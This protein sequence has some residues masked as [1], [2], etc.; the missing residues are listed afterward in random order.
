MY[1]YDDILIV[2]DSWCSERYNME[3]WPNL[4]LYKLTGSS[5]ISPRGKGFGGCA[6]WST[7]NKLYEELK[8]KPAKVIII[9]HTDPSRLPSDNN[10]PMT[11]DMAFRKYYQKGRWDTP[12]REAKVNAAAEY[13]SHLYCG[14]FYRWA[15]EKWFEE[16]DHFL[17]S[18]KSAKIFHLYATDRK[19]PEKFHVFNMG[20]T[21]TYSLF[22]YYFKNTPDIKYCNHMTSQNNFDLALWLN[23]MITNYP[24]HGYVHKESLFEKC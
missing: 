21:V 19:P 16:L 1:D 6:W 15:E 9:I 20:V 3:H 18:Y 8:N 4:L 5:K 24:G 22:N 12:E 7:R 2:G 23:E 14:N 10:F 17:I 13:Y 11:I